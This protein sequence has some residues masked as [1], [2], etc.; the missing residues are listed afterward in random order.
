MKKEEVKITCVGVKCEVKSKKYTYMSGCMYIM[1]MLYWII[2]RERERD[3]VTLYCFVA[4]CG[5][6]YGRGGSE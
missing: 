6:G 1:F 5:C 2:E 3:L 4:L